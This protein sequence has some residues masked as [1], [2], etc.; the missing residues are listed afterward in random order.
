M[1]LTKQI[2]YKLIQESLNYDTEVAA[3]QLIGLFTRDTF[4]DSNDFVDKVNIFKNYDKTYGEL[5]YSLYLPSPNDG[6]PVIACTIGFD[7]L[8][9]DD[10]CRPELEGT[11]GTAILSSAARSEQFRGMG[12]GKI[13]SLIA[14]A[15]L[16]KS[17]FS[18]TTDRDTSNDAGSSLVKSIN[19][20]PINK[21]KPFDYIGWLKGNI[22]NNL[23]YVKKDPLS[24]ERYAEFISDV[25]KLHNH[26]QPLTPNNPNDDCK[27]SVNLMVDKNNKFTNFANSPY[28]PKF[29]PVVKKLLTMSNEQIG[30]LMNLD[31][32]V[33]AYTFD[34]NDQ[35]FKEPLQ[36]LL[37]HTIYELDEMS[38]YEDIDKE[39]ELA[40]DLFGSVYKRK[41]VPRV[42]MFDDDEPEVPLIKKVS[43]PAGTVN[44]PSATTSRGKIRESLN[45][46]HERKLKILLNSSVKDATLAIELMKSLDRSDQEIFD[47]IVKVLPQ[48]T[49]IPL[50][51]FLRQQINFLLAQMAGFYDL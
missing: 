47:M 16:S 15:D 18:V 51:R 9:E 1:K 7:I 33:I 35:S 30:K 23:N 41:N 44:T 45:P 43:Q 50:R 29:A 27:P 46:D 39:K 2:L 31:K 8:H 14:L 38:D 11:K 26:L 3:D 34:L 13:L 36:Y 42:Q 48:V 12:L 21:S 10:N 40:N 37:Q 24:A 4:E 5:L 22:G 20:L 17:K 49:N 32:N 28:L 25:E 19:M 6:R